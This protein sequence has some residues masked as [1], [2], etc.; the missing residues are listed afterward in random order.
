M[1]ALS[2]FV[3]LTFEKEEKKGT[4]QVSDAS[5]SKPSVA[6][7]EEVGAGTERDGNF[8]KTKL[9]KGDKVIVD[10]YSV[11]TINLKLALK[12]SKI[13]AKMDYAVIREDEIL[14]IL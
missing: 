3:F 7:V 13:L 1:K 4:I 5:N 6:V 11:R 12:G 8:I 10:P 2:N 9:K 14:A